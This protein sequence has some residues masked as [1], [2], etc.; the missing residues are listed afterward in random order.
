MRMVEAGA[1]PPMVGPGQQ[2]LVRV[3]ACCARLCVGP[4]AFDDV[5]LFLFPLVVDAYPVHV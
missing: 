1:V 2:H 5:V 4:E 3:V